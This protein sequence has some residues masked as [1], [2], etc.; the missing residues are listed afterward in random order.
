MNEI[1]TATLDY[2]ARPTEADAIIEA[3]RL[4]VELTELELGD[5]YAAPQADGSVRVIDLATDEC[6]KRLGLAPIRKTGVVALSEPTS[7]AHYVKAHAV[8]TCTHLYADRDAGRIVAVLNDHPIDPGADDVEGGWGDH[9]AVLTLRQTP[10]WKA[11][12]GASGRMVDQLAFAEFLEDRALDVITPD[13]AVLLEVVTS[14]EGTKGVAYKS[15]TRLESGEVK[16]RYEETITAKAGQA[17]ELTIPTRIELGISPYEG[18]DPYK[19][20]ARFRYRIDG[21]GGLQLGVVLDRPEDVLRSAFGDV[22]GIIE[23]ATDQIVLH[24]TPAS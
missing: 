12:L 9:R 6:R 22:T 21:S 7:F 1:A 3:A 14:I 8:E 23:L 2:A 13:H 11:W 24:G 17:G 16:F 10:A 15:G 18:M 19:V 20:T 5:I 4:G